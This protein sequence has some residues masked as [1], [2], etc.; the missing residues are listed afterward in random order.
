MRHLLLLEEDIEGREILARML[1]R[2]G[3]TVIQAR[4]QP[5]AL[6]LI[7]DMRVDLVLAGATYQDRADFLSDLRES[8]PDLPIIFLTDY[9]GPEARVPG[10]KY[11]PFSMS[12]NLKFYVNMRPIGLHELDRMIRIALG[13]RRLSQAT[14]LAAA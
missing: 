13:S 4:D 5:D 3:F 11:G 1:R 9:C 7:S 6:S 12:R 2:K 8:R 10:I 14:G